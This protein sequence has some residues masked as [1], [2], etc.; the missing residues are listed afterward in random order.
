MLASAMTRRTGTAED[1]G[2]VAH[3]LER[4]VG[5]RPTRVGLLLLA[6]VLMGLT[7]LACTLAYVG[8]V[9]MIEM[10]PLA[11]VIIEQ[12]GAIWLIAFKLVTMVVTGA[13]VYAS[14]RHRMGEQCAWLCFLMLMALTLHWVQYNEESVTPE[15]MDDIITIAASP[16]TLTLPNWVACSD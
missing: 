10:N 8:G 15:A 1:R 14:R 16:E 4:L 11:R 6:C 2:V 9:G 13:C 12:G 3:A 5:A 7:D